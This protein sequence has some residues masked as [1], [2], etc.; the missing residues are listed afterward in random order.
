MKEDSTVRPLRFSVAVSVLVAAVFLAGVKAAQVYVGLFKGGGHAG[1]LSEGK[2]KLM[3]I[4]TLY[5]NASWF[6]P[7]AKA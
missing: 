2:F 7:A 4:K 5:Q 1:A 3:S 6:R